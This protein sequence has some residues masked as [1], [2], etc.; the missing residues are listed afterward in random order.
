MDRR[1]RSALTLEGS[2][3][4]CPDRRVQCGSLKPNNKIEILLALTPFRAP[5]FQLGDARFVETNERMYDGLRK[6]GMPEGEPKTN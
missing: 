1:L 6:A 5:E 4:F 3:P 2:Q